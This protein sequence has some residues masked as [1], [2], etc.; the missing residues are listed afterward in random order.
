MPTVAEAAQLLERRDVSATELTKACLDRIEAVDGELG[1]YL[2]VTADAALAE[3]AA[4]DKRRADGQALSPLDGVPYAAKDNL[5]TNGVRSTCASRMLANF[6]PPYDATVVARLREAG[7]VLLGKVNLDEFAMGGGTETSAL[8]KTRNPWSPGHVPGGSSGGSAVAVAAGEALF[9]LGSDTGGS[10]RQPAAY[11]GVVG[12]KP[13]YGRVSRFGAAALAPSLDTIGPL[14]RTVAD[15]ALVMQALAGA[16]PL[17]ATASREPVPDFRASLDGGVKGLRIGVPKEL[18]T[19][20]VEAGV[21]QAVEQAL[22]KLTELGATVEEC[23]LPHL[24]YAVATYYV[25]VPAEASS[26]FGRYDGVRYGHRAEGARDSAELIA[27][28]RGEG[29]GPE[30]K[31]RLLL[32]TWLLTGSNYQ[33]YFV[34][35]QKARALIAADFRAAFERFD[36]I[37]CPATPTAAHPAGGKFDPA[38]YWADLW[39]VPAN[40]AGLPALSVPCGFAPTEGAPYGHLP[41]G[42]QLIGKHWAESTLLQAA[43]AFEQAAGLDKQLAA[44]RE[45]ISR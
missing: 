12:L 43:H 16:D 41:V 40:L 24:E 33:E 25:L 5:M 37:A 30:V 3:A 13:T 23:S 8:G 36:V 4:S 44:V 20:Q 11:C 17:D 31:R 1:A 38:G 42:L 39:T 7:T 27:R 9:S 28:S 18:M 34:K 15:A 10:I 45:E 21:R 29:F 14:T 6:V 35:A 2:T 26:A 22:A 19:D 32:G